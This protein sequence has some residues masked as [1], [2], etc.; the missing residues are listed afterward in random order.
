MTSLVVSFIYLLYN[1]KPTLCNFNLR[2]VSFVNEH[3]ALIG[4]APT[5]IS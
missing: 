2:V 3:F 1:Y 4:T 5:F